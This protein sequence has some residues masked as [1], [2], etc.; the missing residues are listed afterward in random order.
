MAGRA[1]TPAAPAAATIAQPMPDT[2]DAGSDE[3]AILQTFTASEIETIFAL[4]LEQWQQMI[5]SISD[6]NQETDP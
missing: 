2:R 4:G 6:T 3:S 1:Y 5:K